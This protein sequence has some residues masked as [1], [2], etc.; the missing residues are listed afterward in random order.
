MNRVVLLTGGNLG[1]RAQVL[2]KAYDLISRRIGS[3][4]ASSPL[5]ESEP[6][7]FD[8]DEAFLNQVLVVETEQEA[9]EVL[10]NTQAIEKELG[11]KRKKTQWVSREIDIDILFFNDQIINLEQLTVPH[12]QLHKRKFTLYALNFV[13][14][15]YQHPVLKQS[16]RALLQQC[17]EASKVEEYYA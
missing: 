16:I 17:K 15:D 2:S 12:K 8:S 13:L 7:G 1:N 10:A 6:W 11:R 5:V 3:I 9:L 14:P 4:S